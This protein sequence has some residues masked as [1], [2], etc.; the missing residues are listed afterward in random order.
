MYNISVMYYSL[1]W[2]EICVVVQVLVA[3]AFLH[4]ATGRWISPGT[5]VSSVKTD[6]RDITELLL[7]VALNTINQQTIHSLDSAKFH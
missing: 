7:K 4:L 3:F 6:R 1:V 5:P 2:V